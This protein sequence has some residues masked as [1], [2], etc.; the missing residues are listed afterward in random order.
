MNNIEKIKMIIIAS[1]TGEERE[2]SG[3]K[4]W[5]KA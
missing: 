5:E 4:S 2:K 3:W 1:T